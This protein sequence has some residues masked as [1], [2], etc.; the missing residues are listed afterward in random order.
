MD[1]QMLLTYV[2]GL[3]GVAGLISVVIDV[4]KRFGLVKDGDAPTWQVGAQ[5]IVLVVVYVLKVFA[6]AFDVDGVDV[7][8]TEFLTAFVPFLNFILD[9]FIGK[10]THKALRGAWLVGTSHTLLGQ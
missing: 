3:A 6:P 5:L 4:L 9:N 7:K 8:L 10:L 1:I 2:L